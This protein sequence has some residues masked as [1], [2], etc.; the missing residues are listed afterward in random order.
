MSELVVRSLPSVL[1]PGGVATAMISWVAST[2]GLTVRPRQWVAEGG[3]DAI[4]LC[5]VAEDALTAAASWNRDTR[6][7]P[8]VHSSRVDEWADYFAAEGIETIAYG[9]LVVRRRR[10]GSPWWAEMR[11]PTGE[12]GPASDQIE[13]M[14]T[15]NDLLADA[16]LEDLLETRLTVAPETRI[17]LGYRRRADS[18][19]ATEPTFHLDV[20]IPVGA[21]LDEA[22]LDVVRRLDGKA[23]LRQVLRDCCGDARATTGA[24]EHGAGRLAERLLRLGLVSAA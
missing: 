2:E 17:D 19:E 12:L 8:E 15:A 7:D 20:G 5:S 1:E 4:L 16:T 22:A 13:R 11:L 9:A 21:S 6:G 23:T 10:S 3:C 18:W 14:L 24:L